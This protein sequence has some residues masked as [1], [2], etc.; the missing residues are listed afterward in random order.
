MRVHL[1]FSYSK[2]F[3]DLANTVSTIVS[4][5]ALKAVFAIF[6]FQKGSP[7][8]DPNKCD[9]MS[10]L[11]LINIFKTHRNQRSWFI[12]IVFLKQFVEENF[13][14]HISSTMHFFLKKKATSNEQ[15]KKKCSDLLKI[16]FL[17]NNYFFPN[18]LVYYRSEKKNA[19]RNRLF[20]LLD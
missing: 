14:M 12:I 2:Q 7:F 16:S 11:I 18:K 10:L 3:R 1:N 20:I 9:R 5:I 13:C 15:K 8:N 4:I 6:S 17:Y 19:Y